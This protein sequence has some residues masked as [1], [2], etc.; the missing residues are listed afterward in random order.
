MHSIEK[1]K[2]LQSTHQLFIDLITVGT[3]LLIAVRVGTMFK[4]HNFGAGI[5]WVQGS[6]LGANLHNTSATQ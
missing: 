5:L 4:S 3:H 6:N 1:Q 2:E